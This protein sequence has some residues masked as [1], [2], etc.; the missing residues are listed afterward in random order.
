MY[1]D[2]VIAGDSDRGFWLFGL[3]PSSTEGP[4]TDN[5]ENSEVATSGRWPLNNRRSYEANNGDGHGT[6]TIPIDVQRI[7]KEKSWCKMKQFVQNITQAGC[8]TVQLKNNF[9][10]GACF[11]MGLP[12]IV[13]NQLTICSYCA[14]AA[15]ARR[16]VRL[17]CENKTMLTTWVKIVR[18]CECLG[19]KFHQF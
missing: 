16:R 5:A 19:C 3:K 12:D 17:T 8:E 7:V 2:Q 11:S 6:M 15:F 18:I 13:H 10:Y 1:A 14:P 9:C 4:S